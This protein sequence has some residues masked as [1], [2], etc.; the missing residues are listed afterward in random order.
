[1]RRFLLSLSR[2]EQ[3]VCSTKEIFR[4][5]EARV[6]IAAGVEGQQ[7]TSTM[8]TDHFLSEMI[9]A[10]LK[11]STARGAFLGEVGWP[12]HNGSLPSPERHPFK[13]YLMTIPGS[14]Q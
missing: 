1:V 4:G 2:I 14:S 9:H 8:L 6:A 13:P 12:R 5:P 10:D 7:L 11:S 3:F